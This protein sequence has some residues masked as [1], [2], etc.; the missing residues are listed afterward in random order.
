MILITGG[1][2]LLGSHLVYELARQGFKI[3]A[4]YRN[5]A[6]IKSVEKVFQYY[7]PN[8]YLEILNL[9]E[10]V[11]GD[12]LDINSLEDA[13]AGISQVY[14]CAGLVSFARRD[15]DK[16]IKINRVGTANVVNVCLAFGVQKIAYVSSTAAIGGANN[17]TISE[18][19][20]WEMS[21][22]TSGYSISKYSAEKE[23]WRGV[24][25]GLDCVIV[26]PSVIFGAGNWEESSLTIF[27]TVNNGLKFY[28][29][30]KNGFVDAR[31]VAEIMVQL[32][33]SDVKNERFLCVGASVS[34]QTLLTKIALHLGKK[35]PSINTPA[36]LVGCAWR[37]AWFVS[38]WKG[39]NPTLTKDSARSSFNLKTY[40]ST[41]V[42][43]ALSRQFRDLDDTVENTIKGRIS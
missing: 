7:S 36:W 34:F 33:Q 5:V 20:K 35:P 37:I 14:H 43:I 17:S 21:P 24:E 23:V 15:F 31:D 32:M 19:T 4:I 9:I 25:E 18:N 28:T 11:K 29:R 16:L 39:T 38:K 10:W 41:K 22:E 8:D 3:R 13:M 40:D 30:G 12:I 27:R 26:N 42:Q 2:G 6:R 1:T